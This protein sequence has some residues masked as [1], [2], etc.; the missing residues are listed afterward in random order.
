[1]GNMVEIRLVRIHRD[2][3]SEDD[4][5]VTGIFGDLYGCSSVEA[6]SP[7]VKNEKLFTFPNGPVAFAPGKTLD[8]NAEARFFLAAPSLDPAE[9]GFPTWLRVGGEM[10]QK[11]PNNPKWPLGPPQFRTFRTRD[12]INPVPLQFRLRFLPA[13]NIELRCDFTFQWLHPV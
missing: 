13:H 4:E 8:I 9:A 11:Y 12:I 5:T 10:F 7:C 2:D 3:F 1:M 6:A